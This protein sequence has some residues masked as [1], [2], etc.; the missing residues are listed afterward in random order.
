[1]TREQRRARRDI[2]ATKTQRRKRYTAQIVFRADP[3]LHELLRA[4]AKAHGRTVAQST[5]FLLDA[6]LRPP[7]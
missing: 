1:M 6:A 4:D 5:R 2:I 7:V 3:E